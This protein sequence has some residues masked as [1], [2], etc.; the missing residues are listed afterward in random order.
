[1]SETAAQPALFVGPPPSARSSSSPLSSSTD[2]MNRRSTDPE[3]FG[4]DIRFLVA[5][6]DGCGLVVGDLAVAAARPVLAR[7]VGCD[8]G[9]VT[10]GTHRADRVDVDVVPLG[11]L[12]ISQRRGEDHADVSFGQ[13]RVLCTAAVLGVCDRL[14]MF[15]PNARS[16]FTEMIDGVAVG[17]RPDELLV[18][19]AMGACS[20]PSSTQAS[21]P[22][23]HQFELPDPA[24]SGVTAI[25]H[26]VVSFG[27]AVSEARRHM[28]RR[29]HGWFSAAAD[30][31]HLVSQWTSLLPGVEP[32]YTNVGG[33]SNS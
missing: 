5:V 16:L 14:E 13:L 18:A 8:I 9:P 31:G 7:K 24:R 27:D 17:Y 22:V 29:V 12:T 3:P 4:Q 21:V 11:E 25:F 30:A 10:A 32:A 33:G 1:M 26:Y 15:R 23:R 20:P 28:S 2:P 19:G 6:E